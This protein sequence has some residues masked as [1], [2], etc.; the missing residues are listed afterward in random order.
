MPTRVDF[1]PVFP[2]LGQSDSF[3]GL[4][5]FLRPGHVAFAVLCT[6]PRSHRFFG[7]ARSHQISSERSQPANLFVL[8]PSAHVFRPTAHRRSVRSLRLPYE[9]IIFAHRRARPSTDPTNLPTV[10]PAPPSP[11]RKTISV[12]AFDSTCDV[13]Q[14][15]RKFSSRTSRTWYLT[16]V[17]PTAYTPT[18]ATPTSV[19]VP[20]LADCPTAASDCLGS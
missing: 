12:R 6:S 17:A 18:S 20:N 14:P 8:A 7:Y 13:V 2:P 1:W 11:D 15:I 10:R 4:C 16:R 19:A 5:L 3:I 9:K